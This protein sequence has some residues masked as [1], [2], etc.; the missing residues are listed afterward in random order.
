MPEKKQEK[1]F[2]RKL[3]NTYRM[4]FYNDSNFEEVWQIRVT[5]INFL[6]LFGTAFMVLVGG[7][8]ALVMFTPMREWVP[9]Y[10][11]QTMR[12]QLVANILRIDSLEYELQTRDKYF[13]AMNAFIAGREPELTEPPA[14]SSN[15]NY[16][17]IIFTRSEQDSLL[18]KQVEEEEQFN[19]VTGSAAAREETSI[20]KTHFFKPIDGIVTSKFDM[21]DKHLGIDLVAKPNEVVKAVLDGTVIISAWTVDTGYVIELQHGSN[22]LTVYK[23]NAS[24]LKKSGDQ[25]KAG[26]AIAIIGNSGD[27]STG[28][29]LHFEIWQSGKPVNPEDYIVF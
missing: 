23:H 27:L 16:S 9:G 22:L 2:F 13:R 6:S 10:P 18:R 14:D 26:D 29:H 19:F 17:K 1:T 12:N 20:L 24:L 7:S 4:V 15:A 25:V 11:T 28:P 21:K 3:K 8:I 5:L